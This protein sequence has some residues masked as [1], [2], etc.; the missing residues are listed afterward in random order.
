MEIF[1]GFENNYINV[2]GF[3][4]IIGYKFYSKGHFLIDVFGGI[5]IKYDII[6]TIDIAPWNNYYSNKTITFINPSLPL[7]LSIGY[8]LYKKK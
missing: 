5:G 8:K 1:Y 4:G 3:Q 2:I 6:K 7:G